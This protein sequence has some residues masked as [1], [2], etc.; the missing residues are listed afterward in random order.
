MGPL[1]CGSYAKME[2]EFDR[3]CDQS[4]DFVCADFGDLPPLLACVHISKST[5]D[6]AALTLILSNSGDYWRRIVLLANIF[7]NLFLWF[8]ENAPNYKCPK[9]K[10]IAGHVFNL[11]QVSC[12]ESKK[13]FNHVRALFEHVYRDDGLCPMPLYQWGIHLRAYWRSCTQEVH[14]T[15]CRR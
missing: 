14:N 11:D 12:E 8:G 1:I 10:W 5:I 2:S 13:V 9:R 4:L 7:P 6:E 3:L 15:L